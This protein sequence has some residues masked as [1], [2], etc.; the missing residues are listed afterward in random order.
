LGETSFDI[1]LALREKTTSVWIYV[2]VT[3]ALM[4]G[5][6]YFFLKAMKWMES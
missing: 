3:I 5:F 1:G 6:T 4:A 2:G